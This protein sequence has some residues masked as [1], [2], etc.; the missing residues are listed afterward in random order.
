M[1]IPSVFF[2]VWAP[3]VMIKAIPGH[4]GNVTTI[5]PRTAEQ[6]YA[7]TALSI[8][9]SGTLDSIGIRRLT[10][11][12]WALTP[13]EAVELLSAVHG[14]ETAADALGE[15]LWIATPTV[16]EMANSL[17]R[18]EQTLEQA[19]ANGQQVIT[20]ADLLPR[21]AADVWKVAGARFSA[22]W[23]RGDLNL[24][25]D[26]SRSVTIQGA[27]AATSYGVQIARDVAQ[28]AAY[29]GATVIAASAY[30]ISEAAHQGALL[31]GKPSI[32]VAAGGL[33]HPRPNGL[34][35]I[36][37]RLGE[38]GLL[39]SPYAPG[40]VTSRR[41]I[42]E[43]NLLLGALSRATVLV[44]SSLGSAATS[45]TNAARMMGRITAAFPGPTTSAT[46]TGPHRLIKDGTA[47]LVESWRD[48]A[49]LLA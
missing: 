34:A 33:D 48:V 24:L 43:T 11:A 47:R 15:R 1:N 37:V 45:A 25:Q 30:G 39:V 14:D 5:D 21:T 3:S 32:M 4:D 27:R 38:E 10:P 19:A 35:D 2:D 40:L 41:R 46:S 36:F 44:E 18:I 49:E 26:L 17:S 9:T 13:A 29:S 28:D 23:T 6:A 7:L 12:F 20:Q 8:A 16:V 22:L 31:A 42:T